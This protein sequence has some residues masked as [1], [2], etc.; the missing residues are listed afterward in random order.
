M[1]AI[2]TSFVAREAGVWAD[3]VAAGPAS[4]MVNSNKMAQLTPCV[5]G[6]P[7]SGFALTPPSVIGFHRN[8]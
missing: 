8:R 6:H 2:S 1:P 4:R 5:I 3:P 7:G